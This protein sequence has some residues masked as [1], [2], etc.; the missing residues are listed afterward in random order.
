M[1]DGIRI[2]GCD[3]GKRRDSFGLVSLFVDVE[4]NRLFVEFA[5]RWLRKDYMYV[6]ERIAR[7]HQQ[8]H[9]SDILVE[10]NNT[11]EHVIEMLRKKY[12]LPVR[13][14]TTVGKITDPRKH[15]RLKTMSK[16]EMVNWYVRAKQRH[17]ALFP[18]SLNVDMLELKRQIAIFAEYRTDAG[19]VTYH[20]PGNE[21]DDLAV[22]FLIACFGA[23]RWIRIGSA[24]SQLVWGPLTYHDPYMDALGEM[25]YV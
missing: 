22:S 1:L 19:N 17:I 10:Q 3:P 15:H 13:A 18:R 11:G 4:K 2:C 7:Y 12:A 8:A 16:P 5:K 14:V 24:D 25:T 21:H 9:W 23:L 20:A 6:E